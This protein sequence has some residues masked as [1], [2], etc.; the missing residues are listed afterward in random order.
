MRARSMEEI[1]KI[2]QGMKFKRKLFGGV[3]ELDVIRQMS[4]LHEAYQSVLDQ[5][6]A[7]YSA[8]ITER[9]QKIRQLENKA[10]SKE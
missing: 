1:A 3:D 2:I 4:S 7:Y 10:G 5:H 6:C 9:D 8:L